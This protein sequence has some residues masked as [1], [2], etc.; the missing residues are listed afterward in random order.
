MWAL[1][2][3]GVRFRVIVNDD[4]TTERWRQPRLAPWEVPRRDP[5]EPRPNAPEV[6]AQRRAAQRRRRERQRARHAAICFDAEMPVKHRGRASNIWGMTRN[7]NL[8]GRAIKQK[9]HAAFRS[10]GSS[11]GV[12]ME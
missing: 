1:N 10:V 7:V 12:Q 3:S 5:A 11:S 2:K 8:G 9:P 6:A 4:G